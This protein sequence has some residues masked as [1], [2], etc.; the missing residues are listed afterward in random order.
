MRGGDPENLLQVLA[1]T[2]PVHLPI[3]SLA[4]RMELALLIGIPGSGKSTFCRQKF[5]ASHLRLSLDVLG[6]RQR[7]HVLF[8]ACLAT[9]ARVVI[10]NTN[11]SP[12][13]RA[14]FIAPARASGFSV[15]GYYL[16][17]DLRLALERNA[18]RTGRARVPDAGVMATH[19]RLSLP[20]FEEGFDE[21][22]FVAH[23]DLGGFDVQ[24]WRREEEAAVQVLVGSA[25]Y[26]DGAR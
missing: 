26:K 9:Q 18:A 4:H 7:E 19:A 24:P 2:S 10:D 20:A 21:L 15:V 13:Q 8:H 5:F 17:T 12:A 22:F 11:A 3:L 6:N 1:T 25:V 14:R 23:D 16:Q